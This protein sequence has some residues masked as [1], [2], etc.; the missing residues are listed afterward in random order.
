MQGTFVAKGREPHQDCDV[1]RSTADVNYSQDIE[2]VEVIGLRSPR[3]SA[4]IDHD[5]VSL[6]HED[7]TL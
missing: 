1:P 3:G 7:P 6:V 4:A 2:E 5:R